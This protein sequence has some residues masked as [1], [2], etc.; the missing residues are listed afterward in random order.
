MTCIEKT[1]FKG[2]ASVKVTTTISIDS[3]TDKTLK[4]HHECDYK[5]HDLAITKE[6]IVQ[7][8]GCILGMNPIAAITGAIKGQSPAAC[9][10][11]VLHI[12]TSPAMVVLILYSAITYI[13]F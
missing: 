6:I 10:A 1:I 4:T 3:C 2:S 7:Y 13:N 12:S 11:S 5:G 8:G 9:S